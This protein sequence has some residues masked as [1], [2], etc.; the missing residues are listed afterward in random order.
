MTTQY[1]RTPNGK[2]PDLSEY[3]T[4]FQP[5]LA[6]TEDGGL[7]S[8]P[9]PYRGS[10]NG[11]PRVTRKSKV[12]LGYWFYN[13]PV[14]QKQLLGLF[15][16][17]AISIL[18]LVGASSLL[19]IFGGRAQL[20]NQAKSE[21]AVSQIQYDIKVNQMG[22]G[23][24]GQSDNPAIIE[25][26]RAH[27]VG[28]PP[29]SETGESVKQI[30]QNEITAR[31]I[32][33]A[34]L[35]G[36]D[37]QIIASAN[38]DRTGER[39][40]P[41]GL[42]GTVLAHPRQLK[43]SAIVSWSELE[44]E[45]PPLPN[46]FAN[47]DALVRYTVTPVRD[48]DT[49]GV[50]G[51]LISGDIVNHKPEIPEGVLTAFRSGYSAI[52]AYK[53]N[54]EYTLA[55]ALDLG[56]KG[57]LELAQ[58][59]RRL[60]DETILDQAA[61]GTGAVT[62]RLM[63]GDQTY[64]IAA[65]AISNFKGEPVAIL[66]RGTSEAALNALIFNS[67]KLQLIIATL[68]LITDIVLAGLLGRSIVKPLRRL[69]EAT[70]QFRMGDRRA[71]SDIF[72]K[73]E[74]G[75]VAHA[76]NQLADSIVSSEAAL[77]QQ[78]VYQSISAERARLLT[79]LTIRIR[80][81][82]NPEEI[83][84]TTVEGVREVL[85]VD[86]MLIYQF[87]PDFQSGAITAEAVA[88]GWISA[89]GGVIE[90]PMLPEA[91]ERFRSGRISTVEN[92]NQANLTHCHCEILKRLEVQ[93]NIVAPIVVGDDLMGLLCAHQCS[94]PRAWE[95][96]EIDLV[97]QISTQVGYALRQA[98]LMQQQRATAD[99]ER[100]LNQIVSQLRESLDPDQ[101]FST[102]VRESR[103]VLAADRVVIYLFDRHWQGTIVAESVGSGWPAAMGAQIDDPCFANKYV[104][105]Y[106][107]GRVQATENIYDA[108]LT[109]CYLKQLEPFAV[110]AN[111]VAPILK[112]GKLLGLLIAHQCAAPRAWDGLDITF[113]KQVSIQ[114]GFALEQASLFAQLEQSRLEAEALS[115]ERRQQ[116]EM[117]Q[118]QLVELLGDV[119]GAS[120]GDL[121][122]RADVT[123]GEI[124]TVADFFN[125]IIESLRQI[126]TKVKQSATQVNTSLENNENEIRRLADNALRQSKET[127]QTLDSVE[128]MTDSIQMVAASARQAAVVARSASETAE[129]GGSAMDLTVQNIL[130]LR[131][132]VAETAKKVKRLGESSQQI[133]K[134]VSL[135]NQIAMQTNLLAI[136]AGIEAA[137]AGE[138][139]QGFAVVAEEVGE[140]AARSS[141][142]TQEIERIVDTIQR[143]TG[144]VVDA[145][146][147]STMQVVEGTHR[148]ED[149]K[150]SLTKILEVS[151]QIDQLVQSISE[152]TVSQVQ[153][154]EG[155]SR[156]MKQ[157]AQ[158]SE[159][160]SHSSRQVS[161]ALRQTVEIA[162]ELQ[163]SVGAFKV[164]D[165]M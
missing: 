140:L 157:I 39:F 14:R 58:P 134:V 110:Q 44:K 78:S 120:Q 155:V 1:R 46:G 16:S 79:A 161:G 147:Q 151:Y 98:N 28:S 75:Q 130:A 52:Y 41:E 139:G 143:E 60:T 95:E 97:Q 135:I 112:D 91:I 54:G 56:D 125:S 76:F 128:Q 35:V 123:A 137:R 87:H 43:A 150:Q 50:I 61:N 96:G 20:L 153:T 11:F 146:E 117:L 107:Q 105:K 111:L 126:V 12:P 25:A 13:L 93:A 129:V 133:S 149:A 122:V 49:D 24:R 30:L 90:D 36:K 37:L 99:R 2:K 94:G 67:L 6:D 160:T 156:L 103:Q 121:T 69:Q 104:E 48:S 38:A 132:T 102:V 81:S 55:T 83:L 34:T 42:V 62:Q 73:D 74:V 162:Q 10:A 51:A 101:I 163:A 3:T 63:V 71:R 40:D 152:M 106:Q 17:E 113:L 131:E 64:T 72:S 165:S 66:V 124:G 158:V 144:E 82:L 59:N 154:S 26:A 115:E 85:Q 4:S 148:V 53:P 22:F 86:R 141:V 116:Q 84:N 9:S 119:E 27:A 92:L 89:L 32:E 164:G 18:G 80:Q 23:F 127:T 142:A 65:E 8:Q 15:T 159:E 77:R 19:I 45:S 33:Y 109:E 57:N 47:R 138:E 31:N 108:G 145:M 100:R 68:A 136:N 21:L 7:T 70:R 5:S 29:P 114:L 88:P 118:M